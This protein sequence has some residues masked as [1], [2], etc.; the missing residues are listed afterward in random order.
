MIL[1]FIRDHHKYTLHRAAFRAK[2]AADAV[3]VHEFRKKIAVSAAL[4]LACQIEG[5]YRTSLHA[6]AAA[7]TVFVMKIR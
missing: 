7:D 6:D 3:F 4:A 2:P 1:T 5:A